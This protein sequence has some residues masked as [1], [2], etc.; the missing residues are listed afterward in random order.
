MSIIGFLWLRKDNNQGRKC[1]FSIMYTFMFPLIKKL[2][3]FPIIFKKKVE[4]VA[5]KSVAVKDVLAVI[6]FNI[7]IENLNNLH[8][9]GNKIK[10]FLHKTTDLFILI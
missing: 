1:L 7:K 10:E 3:H 6:S 9:Q 5:V 2:F 4:A 8:L